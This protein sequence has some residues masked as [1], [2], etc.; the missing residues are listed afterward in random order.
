MKPLEFFN[1]LKRAKIEDLRNID[2]KSIKHLFASNEHYER[3]CSIL[4]LDGLHKI[5]TTS[6]IIIYD[7]IED[8]AY[9]II[10]DPEQEV[11]YCDLIELVPSSII[12]EIKTDWDVIRYLYNVPEGFVRVQGDLY[13]CILDK[14]SLRS[15]LTKTIKETIDKL[16]EPYFIDAFSTFYYLL[17][18]TA[19]YP[20]T[21]YRFET[22]RTILPS[23]NKYTLEQLKSIR[24]PHLNKLLLKLNNIIE[25]INSST[26]DLSMYIINPPPFLTKIKNY[27]LGYKNRDKFFQKAVDIISDIITQSMVDIN[28]I[29]WIQRTI[30]NLPML[31]YVYDI[32][33]QKMILRI[34]NNLHRF[35]KCVKELYITLSKIRTKD[36][37]LNIL[38]RL[39]IQKIKFVRNN[40]NPHI[41]QFVGVSLKFAYLTI[42]DIVIE[43]K[44]HGKLIIP[45]NGYN[46]LYLDPKNISY[47]DA[48][49]IPAAI[50]SFRL[51]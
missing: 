21:R 26:Y 18:S 35:I 51:A 31:Y 5:S 25:D 20:T 40:G 41:V 17:Y 8:N 24:N 36:L 12:K 39:K 34:L 11:L 10:Y 30:S 49:K 32:E 42:S 15:L 14:G 16:L 4:D 45:I 13:I 2:K 33:E 29:R 3:F 1:F 9:I 22:L 38:P 47:E 23:P 43:H 50:V 37:L 44:E 19:S 6:Y 27:I 46:P 7:S 28:N 48:Y